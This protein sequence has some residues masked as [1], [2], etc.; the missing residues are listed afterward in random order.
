MGGHNLEHVI[1][2]TAKHISFTP[3]MQTMGGV[4]S[5]VIMP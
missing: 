4:V 2:S 3:G 1:K 5:I